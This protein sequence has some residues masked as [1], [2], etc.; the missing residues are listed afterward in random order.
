MRVRELH[1]GLPRLHY[2]TRLGN[3]TFDIDKVSILDGIRQVSQES[4]GINI[5]SILTS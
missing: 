3:N 1:I 4:I 5:E 2:C